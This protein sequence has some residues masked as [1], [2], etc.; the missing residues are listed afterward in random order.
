MSNLQITPGMEVA[1]MPHRRSPPADVWEIATVLCAGPVYIQLTDS[2]LFAT[3][4]GVGLNSGG[5]IVPATDEH[6][7]AL[8]AKAGKSA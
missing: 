8:L 2:R 4:G 6:R 5:Y 3:V 1:V 7:A